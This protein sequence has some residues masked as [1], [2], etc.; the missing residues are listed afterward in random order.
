MGFARYKQEYKSLFRLGLPVLVT[1]VCVITVSFA[2]TL[3][4]GA[5]GLDELAAS[6][7]VNSL[8][9]VVLVMLMGFAGGITP[10]IGALFS[11]GDVYAEGFAE[12]QFP[13]SG[14]VYC[15]YGCA[16]LFH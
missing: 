1:Q 11:R 9:L 15:D 13:D 3:M 7:F 14:S 5:Y 6:A 8:F 2:D 10:L 16:V 4:V 12:A